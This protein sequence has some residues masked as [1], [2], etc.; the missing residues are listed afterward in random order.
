MLWV[1]KLFQK[2]M[3]LDDL[4]TIKKKSNS[5]FVAY[6]Y[7]L[8]KVSVARVTDVTLTTGDQKLK[9]K[10]AI[11]ELGASGS[12]NGAGGI[13]DGHPGICETDAI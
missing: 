6:F 8:F 12:T 4:K 13:S 3:H 11:A 10:N 1:M 7:D 2:P 9:I 5:A